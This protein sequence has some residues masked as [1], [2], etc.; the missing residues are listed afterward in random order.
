[1]GLHVKLSERKNKK[2]DALNREQ[3]HRRKNK[4]ECLDRENTIARSKKSKDNLIVN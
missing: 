2:Q 1:M 3:E 4:T